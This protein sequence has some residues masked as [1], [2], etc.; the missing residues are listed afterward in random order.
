MVDWIVNI[1]AQRNAN[2]ELTRKQMN[3]SVEHQVPR[4]L[5]EGVPR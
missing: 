4:Y 2:A 3:T 1:I 5:P